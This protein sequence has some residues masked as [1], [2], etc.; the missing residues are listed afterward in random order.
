MAFTPGPFRFVYLP[1]GEIEPLFDFKPYGKFIPHP[2]AKPPIDRR[3]YLGPPDDE[4]PEAIIDHRQS[5]EARQATRKRQQER[6]DLPA[7]PSAAPAEVEA[8]P[9]EPC[10][11]AMAS[12]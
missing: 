8:A 1:D 2:G 7:E 10:M 9:L 3:F 4:I 12:D 11:A 6:K 5:A